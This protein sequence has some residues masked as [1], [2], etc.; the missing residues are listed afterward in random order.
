MSAN[1]KEWNVVIVDDE[2]HNIGVVQL[3]LQYHGAKTHVAYS[4]MDGLEAVNLHKP[5]FVLLDLQMPIMSGFEVLGI[6]RKDPRLCNTTV[7][8]LTSHA[9]IGDYERAMEAGFDGYITKPISVQNFVKQIGEILE[10]T[11]ARA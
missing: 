6:I 4:G 3:V 1:P 9:M 2:P 7:I 5:D 11:K 8:A 10:K